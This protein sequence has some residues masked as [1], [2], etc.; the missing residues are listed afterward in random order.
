MRKIRPSEIL[1]ASEMMRLRE[2]VDASCL[3]GMRDAAMIELLVSTGMRVT[4]LIDLRVTDVLFDEMVVLVNGRDGRDVPLNSRAYSVLDKY[5]EAVEPQGFLF[6]SFNKGNNKQKQLTRQGTWKI[7]KQYGEAAGIQ[8]AISPEVIRNSFAVHYLK[9]GGDIQVLQ[10]ILGHM[11]VSSTL[12]Y[13]N[14]RI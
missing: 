7:I 12:V 10:G 5:I 13:K 2:V 9:N 1:D 6:V 11:E 4:E 8:K 14:V 3:R